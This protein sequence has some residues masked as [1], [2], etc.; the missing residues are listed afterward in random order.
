MSHKKTIEELIAAGTYRPSRHGPRLQAT[1]APADDFAAPP[2]IPASLHTRWAEVVADLRAVGVVTRTDVVLLARAFSQLDNAEKFQQLLDK[3][4]AEGGDVSSLAK[5][6]NASANATA[7]FL[8]LVITVR[9]AVRQNKSRAPV[10]PTGYRVDS[11]TGELRKSIRA[12]LERPR[13]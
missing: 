7:S 10:T 11:K 5:I 13:G 3:Q 9:D 2:E 6:Q 4:L 8:R 1:A 12:V